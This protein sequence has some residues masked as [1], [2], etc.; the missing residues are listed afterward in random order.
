MHRAPLPEHLTAGSFSLRMSDKAGISRT[1]TAA[2]DLAT[3]SRGIR[4]H[5]GSAAKG[6][7]ALRAYTELDDTSALTHVSAARVWCA[8]LGWRLEG[9]WRVH[10]SR[11]PGS[12]MPRRVNVAGHLLT[13]LPGELV[14]YDGVR[15]TSPARTWLDLAS[16]TGVDELVI[17]GDSLVCS[18]GQEFPVPR[19][20]L[21]TVEEL[22]AMVAKHSGIRGARLA[23]AALELIR[24]GADSRPETE[25]RLA[26]VRAGLPEPELNHVLW[27]VDGAP[28]LWPD[29]AYLEWRISIQY[30]GAGHGGTEQ[31][32][33]DIRRESVTR[34]YG[35]LEVRVSKDDLAGERPAVVRKVRAAL[36]SRGWRPR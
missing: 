32:R 3:V 25:M 15:L 18:H 8:A 5:L 31:Y 23:R 13:F 27:G 2:K 16:M 28:V 33:R 20:P 11:R 7:A 36:E 12:S 1:R 29:A 35:W 21:C 14:E 4:V 22:R 9:D 30:D 6:A 19:D 10:L 34:E 24:A 17:A 26:L